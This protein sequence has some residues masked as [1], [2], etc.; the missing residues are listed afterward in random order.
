MR[1]G[2]YGNLCVLPQSSFEAL[3]ASHESSSLP[4]GA[5]VYAAACPFFCCLLRIATRKTAKGSL[6]EARRVKKTCQ[7]HVFSQ[8]GEQS[9]IATRT[10]GFAKGL[11]SHERRLR[12]NARAASSAVL[13]RRRQPLTSYPRQ[14]PIC[15]ANKSVLPPLLSLP[16]PVGTVCSHNVPANFCSHSAGICPCAQN[17]IS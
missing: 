3:Q 9:M 6:R 12:E 15:R 17:C 2:E 1:L 8:S 13:Q 11:K 10:A 5:S 4:E 14:I 16:P 7:W